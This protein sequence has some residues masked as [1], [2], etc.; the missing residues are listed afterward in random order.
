MPKDEIIRLRCSRAQKERLNKA[1]GGPGAL[2]AFVLDAALHRA[3]ELEHGSA[4]RLK[5]N[6]I[7]LHPREPERQAEPRGIALSDGLTL[8]QSKRTFEPD[9]K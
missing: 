3:A 6:D 8:S 1:A 2:S 4:T 5:T 9:P 7:Q